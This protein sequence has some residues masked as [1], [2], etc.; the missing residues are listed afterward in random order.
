MSEIKESSSE[1]HIFVLSWLGLLL[2]WLLLLLLLDF[3]VFLLGIVLLAS[4]ACSSGGGSSGS[5]ELLDAAGDELVDGLALERC[6]D[7]VE[8][9][10]IDVGGHCAEDG[11]NVSG[12]WVTNTTY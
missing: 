12:G 2:D 10:V 11:L 8:V 4:L 9:V 6:D 7:S 1:T 5:S 3:L